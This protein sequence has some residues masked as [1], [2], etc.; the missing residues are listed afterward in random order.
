MNLLV[1]RRGEGLKIEGVSDP[2]NPDHRVHSSGALLPG[3]D[4]ILAAPTFQK[5]LDP[6]F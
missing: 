4:A 3:P 1:A 5:W 6:T 2:A